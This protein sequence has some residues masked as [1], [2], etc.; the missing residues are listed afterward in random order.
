[1]APDTPRVLKYLPD[2]NPV[3]LVTPRVGAHIGVLA[4]LGVVAAVTA[5]VSSRRR[6]VFSGDET[7]VSLHVESCTI[8][9]GSSGELMMPPPPLVTT[10]RRVS[11]NVP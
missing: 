5:S 11:L 8:A 7:P 6:K 3:A 9:K 10:T 4:A 1:L 2:V